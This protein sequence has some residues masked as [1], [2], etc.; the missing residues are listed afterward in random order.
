MKKFL[1]YGMIMSF[2]LCSCKKDKSIDYASL[3]LGNWVNTQ[4][5]NKA[6]LTDAS[7]TFKYSPDNVQTYATGFI[8]DENNKTWMENNSYIYSVDGNRIIIDGDNTLGSNFHME[9]IILSADQ[10]TL[11]Y[12]VSKFMVDGVEYPDPKTYTNKKVTSDLSSQFV[13][14]WY[15]KATTPGSPDTSYHYWQYF[16][17]GHFGYYYRDNT[18]TWI[19]KPDN[20]GFYFL[21]GNLLASNYTNDLLTGGTGK[22]FECWNI[23]IQGDTMSW[24]GLRENGLVTSFQMKKVAGPPLFYNN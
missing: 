18:G 8:L 4:V 11:T 20:N 19:N 10:Q 23:T 5:D 7:F 15:G 3:I 13:G 1:L 16:A 17:D 6:V 22:A 12:S 2:L 24:T 9:F 21:Y 14:T